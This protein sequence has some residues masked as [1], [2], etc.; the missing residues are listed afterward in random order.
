[1]YP[2]IDTQGFTLFGIHVGPADTDN[3]LEAAG[4]ALLRGEYPYYEKIF[5]GQPISQMPGALFLAIPFHILR[6][7]SYQNVFW[8][9]IFYLLT[10][11]LFR[12]SRPALFLLGLMI[13]LP[14]N[15]LCQALVGVDDI[16][17]SLYV[18]AFMMLLIHYV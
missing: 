9:F 6:Y 15:F 3:G 18:L 1:M 4:G 5:S 13:C 10:K 11:K 17:N 16:S 2:R 14:P 7:S 12:D 8:I